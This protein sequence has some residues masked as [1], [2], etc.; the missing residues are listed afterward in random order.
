MRSRARRRT[1]NRWWP[2]TIRSSVLASIPAR[3]GLVASSPIQLPSWALPFFSAVGI[4][5]RCGVAA[6]AI[7]NAAV[8]PTAA[9][10][11]IDD[12]GSG[13]PARAEAEHGDGCGS[14]DAGQRPL[15]PCG[16]KVVAVQK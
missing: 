16:A 5:P 7:E 1:V 8:P 12:R 11:P 4:E 9:R 13:D 10:T 14:R 3:S 2:P 15:K 6:V